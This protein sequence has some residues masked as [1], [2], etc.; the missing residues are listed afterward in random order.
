MTGQANN[1]HHGHGAARKKGKMKNSFFPHSPTSVGSPRHDGTHF[2][3]RSL[4]QRTP[5]QVCSLVLP[6]PLLSLFD[7]G[8]GGAAADATAAATPRTLAATASSDASLDARSACAP[9]V[10]HSSSVSASMMSTA[11]AS[12]RGAGSVGAGAVRHGPP[13]R[14]GASCDPLL[15]FR[16]RFAVVGTGDGRLAVYSLVD[17]DAR[18]GRSEDVEASDRRRREEWKAE[19]N[20]MQQCQRTARGG[21]ETSH[22]PDPVESAT[23]KFTDAP[24]EEHEWEMRDRMHRRQRARQSVEPIA[25]V[26]LPPDGQGDDVAQ[27]NINEDGNAGTVANPP[28]IIA[29]CATPGCGTS[30]IEPQQVVR[31]PSTGADRG[32]TEATRDDA[33]GRSEARAAGARPRAPTFGGDLLGHVAALTDDSRVHVLEFLRGAPPAATEP[34]PGRD[35]GAAARAPRVH[36]LL[37]FRT[38]LLGATCICMHPVTDSDRT[39]G[40]PRP[41]L[42]TTGTARD[43]Q[44]LRLCVGHQSGDIVNFRIFSTFEAAVPKAFVPGNPSTHT[45]KPTRHRSLVP[46]T[47]SKSKDTGLCLPTPPGKTV[48]TRPNNRADRGDTAPFHRTL[49]EPL[50]APDVA[51]RWAAPVGGPAEA[52]L[53]WRGRLEAPVRAVSSPGWR[54]WGREAASPRDGAPLVVGTERRPREAARR[55]AR[56]GARPSP[57]HRAWSPALSLEAIDASLAEREFLRRRRPRQAPDRGRGPAAPSDDGPVVPLGDCGVWPAPGREMKDGWTRGA[58]RRGVDPRDELYDRLGVRPSSVTNR[59]CCF[60]GLNQS[61]VSASSDGTVAISHYNPENGSWGIMEENQFMFFQRCIGI[62]T[63]DYGHRG[64][65][66]SAERYVM[67]CLRGGTVYLVPV[68]EFRTGTS[69]RATQRR[70]ITM[71]AAPSDA[72]GNEDGAVRFVQTF[73]GGMARCRREDVHVDGESSD[74]MVKSVALVGWPGGNIDVFE[75][76]P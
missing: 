42:A 13:P 30:L 62:G 16:G 38:P 47:R 6:P 50:I 17:F 8:G 5:K 27:I 12:V 33:P 15:A 36:V 14:V 26:S 44:R 52:A 53:C 58:R 18:G 48:T 70:A 72:D 7:D 76:N 69:A 73:A 46:H 28:V 24:E 66:N 43:A 31:A 63:V 37:S 35:G 19:D 2:C 32:A 3:P 51:K 74:S 10:R 20:R 39:G 45:E 29:L 40:G 41:P 71:F 11:A 54:G 59:I 9:S 55:E 34:W 4:R 23:N 49:S 67:C 60:E 65:A 75:V 68:E 56:H 25:I 57:S 61:F 64:N 21:D 1:T 22:E